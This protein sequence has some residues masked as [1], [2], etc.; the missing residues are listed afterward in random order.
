M[1][2]RFDGYAQAPDG[3]ASDGFAVTPHDTNDLSEPCR[4]LYVGTS[5]DI[6][7]ITAG[8]TTLTFA[9]LPAGTLLPV[10]CTRVLDIGTTAT[11]ILALM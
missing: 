4:A 6:A 11:N 3:P 2:T 1:P 10:R 8:G 5:G 9:N 7:A